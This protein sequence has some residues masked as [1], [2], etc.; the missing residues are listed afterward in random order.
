MLA[1][2][3]SVVLSAALVLATTSCGNPS[4]SRQVAD[5]FMDLYYARMNVADAVQL[6]G[7]AARTR[8]DGEL[9]ALK[10]VPR[11][12]PGGEPRVTFSLT[13]G[14]EP[15]PTQATYVYHVV[16]HT[17]DVGKVGATLTLT[18]QDGH[19]LVTSLSEVEGPP[20]S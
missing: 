20:S 4:P 3:R 7:G 16:S 19:W 8:L 13:S 9:A 15:A 14:S 17:P 2:I 12:T 11:E 1:P 10:G 6:T 5:R 18:L